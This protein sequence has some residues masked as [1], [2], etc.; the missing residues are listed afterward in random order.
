MTTDFGGRVDSS[1]LRPSPTAPVDDVVVVVVV[2]C[3]FVCFRF[4]YQ[5]AENNGKWWGMAAG[6]GGGLFSLYNKQYLT[7]VCECCYVGRCLGAILMST[8]AARRNR[9]PHGRIQIH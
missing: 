7:Q 8:S 6:G 9:P 3:E 1:I 2:M 5:Q 4:N